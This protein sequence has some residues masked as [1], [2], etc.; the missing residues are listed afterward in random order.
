MKVHLPNSAHLQN[1]GNFLK[2]L[3]SHD[4][5]QLE[6]SMHESWV[7]VHPAVLA[8]TACAG[9]IVEHMGGKHYGAVSRIQA[10]HYLIRM[11]LFDYVK[12][13][14]RRQITEHEAS[15]RFIPLTQIRSTDDLRTAITNLVPLLH[16]PREIADP[17]KYVFSEMVRNS[18]EHSQSPVGAFVCAQYYKTSNRISIGIADAG[19]GILEHMQRFHDVKTSSQAITLALQP[20]ITGTTSRIGG[21]EFNAGAGLFFTKSIA[22]LSKNFFILYSGDSAFR[23]LRGRGDQTPE[24]HPDPTDDHHSLPSNLPTWPGTL[25]GI[26]INVSADTEFSDLLDSIRKSYFLDVKRKKD[27]VKKI[28]F[29]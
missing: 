21:N 28:K 26:D 11:K 22:A 10:L 3:D 17:I 13:D 19:I 7:S 29:T 23:L 15:G 2:T 12:V 25:V 5:A 6:F 8:L 1:F 27:Y 9:A 4:F 18:L 16:A 24:L 20:G 14:P